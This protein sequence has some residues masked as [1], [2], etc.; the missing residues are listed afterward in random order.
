[1]MKN[2]RVLAAAFVACAPLALHAQ[3]QSVEAPL[4][5]QQV[6]VACAL[7]PQLAV[8]SP[9]ALHVIG[10][11]EPILRSDFTDRDTLVL[12]AGTA[13]GVQLGQRYF[14]RRPM[15]PSGWGVTGV[16]HTAGWIRVVAVDET[17]AIAVADQI[18]SYIKTGDF[19]VPFV[20]PILPPDLA[21]VDRSIDPDFKVMGRVLFGD[22]E[23]ENAAVGEYMLIDRGAEQ[24]LAAGSRFA[25]YR[26]VRR[27]GAV[28]ASGEA[29]LPLAAVGEGV[30]VTTGPTL[31]V[32]RILSANDAVHR[33]DYVV[34]RKK[35]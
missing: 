29:A 22:N 13:K 15:R 12:D 18:C 27:W 25:I 31:S 4:S 28:D 8:P 34:P 20:A 19:L 26:D 5:A 16:L 7:P 3:T 6:A 32:L 10:S 9:T 17:R 2:P 35:N 11:Q 1:M 21:V 30:V 24:G 33:G 23:R 14:V